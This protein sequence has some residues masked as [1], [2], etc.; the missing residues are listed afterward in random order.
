MA[1]ER[2][3]YII[4][5]TIFWIASHIILYCICQIREHQTLQTSHGQGPHVFSLSDRYVSG[6]WVLTRTSFFF[7]ETT[8]SITWEHQIAVSC[9]RGTFN[10]SS[11]DICTSTK[12]SEC[13][14]WFHSMW[15]CILLNALSVSWYFTIL[16]CRIHKLTN[17]F[18]YIKHQI[19]SVFTEKYQYTTSTS[20]IKVKLNSN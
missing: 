8:R 15:F 10:L 13:T 17:D 6:I 16:W 14:W 12:F 19:L 4:L 5:G 20:T 11:P 7:L 9:D 2:Q 3:Y 18:L 1:W